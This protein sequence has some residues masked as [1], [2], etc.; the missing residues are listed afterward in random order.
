MN[1][2]FIKF[3]NSNQTI[4]ENFKPYDLE[5]VISH[6]KL[7]NFLMSYISHSDF[8]NIILHGLPGIGKSCLV[9]ACL[10]ELFKDESF[11][12]LSINASEK[13]GMTMLKDLIL[14]F[15]ISGSNFSKIKLKIVVLDE[16]DNLTI[17]AQN[18]IK[19]FIDMYP[20]IRFVLICNYENKVSESL[21]FRCLYYKMDK[22]TQSEILENIKKILIFENIHISTSALIKV[23]NYS[24]NDIRKIMNI[25]QCLKI[26]YKTKPIFEHNV[27]KYIGIIT[28]EDIKDLYY[29][30][31]TLEIEE[32]LKVFD[33]YKYSDLLQLIY[34]IYEN[35]KLNYKQ[36]KEL[37]N[38]EIL[39]Y[40]GISYINFY[41]FLSSLF[42]N[43]M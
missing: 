42:K 20:N 33:I 29:K 5:N 10:K 21:K 38:L 9:N 40:E 31:K 37:A 25:L 36:I 28:K 18:L 34:D 8:P 1:V 30:L 26:V 35:I 43:N 12:V 16:M 13:R 11:N 14:N 15:L 32:F 27:I 24:K 3:Y 7:K 4:T 17:E 39:V 41:T 2:N 6:E 19:T 23:I 22:P